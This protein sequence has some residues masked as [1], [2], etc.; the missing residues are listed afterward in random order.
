MPLVK[1]LTVF[2]LDFSPDYSKLRSPEIRL[3]AKA[4][5]VVGSD[6]SGDLDNAL[7]DPD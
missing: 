7:K 4:L 5:V 3:V 6:P 2:L 1:A